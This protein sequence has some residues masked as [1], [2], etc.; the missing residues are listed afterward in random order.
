MD[1]DDDIEKVDSNSQVEDTPHNLRQN[2]HWFRL[3][4][5]VGSMLVL[6]AVAAIVMPILIQWVYAPRISV[7]SSNIVSIGHNPYTH[8]L[9]VEFLGGDIYEY[10]GVP[11]EIYKDFLEADSH[12]RF[13][14]RQ[15]KA[16]DY[17]FTKIQ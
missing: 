10:S 14:H 4:F 3:Q 8:T 17:E 6:T 9:T 16:A 15:I 1:D 11:R 2:H 5:S 12:G 7:D 13:F